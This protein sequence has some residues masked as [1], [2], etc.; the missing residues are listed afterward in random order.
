MPTVGV[1]PGSYTIQLGAPC[2]DDINGPVSYGVPARGWYDVP[3]ATYQGYW[4]APPTPILPPSPVPTTV[5]LDPY[6]TDSKLQ[7]LRAPTIG[8]LRLD[9]LSIMVAVAI[10]I[11]FTIHHFAKR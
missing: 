9:I 1:A 3:S 10:G 2:V 7:G 5:V 6:G 11:G 4:L 8:G